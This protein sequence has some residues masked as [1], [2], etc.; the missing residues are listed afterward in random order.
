MDKSC[1][2]VCTKNGQV[3][4]VGEHSMLD[5]SP[6]IPLIRRIVRT[7]YKKLAARYC[8]DD[9]VTSAASDFGDDND[10]DDDDDDD[11]SAVS[12]IFANVWT[13][14]IKTLETAVQLSKMAQEQYTH[15]TNQYE[16]QVLVFDG[17]GKKFLKT[18]GM[19]SSADAV[20]QMAMQLASYR[21]FHGKQVATY[22]AALAR[23]F[24]HGRTATARPVSPQSRA[25]LQAMGCNDS[26]E[27]SSLSSSC[28]TADK[29]QVL[30]Q[31][32]QTLQEYQE[33]ASNG[34]CV[35]RHLFGLSM[36]INENDNDKVAPPKMFNDALY[37]RSK[38]W[39]LST[40]AFI[41][42]PGFGPVTDDGLGIGYCVAGDS[43]T[44]TVSSRKENN[45]VAPFCK[46][47]HEALTEI[48]QLLVENADATST[49]ATTTTTSTAVS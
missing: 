26:D 30:R 2:L 33:K 8:K 13:S 42:C 3:A 16:H 24:L 34:M 47:L 20:I 40:S 37:Q 7:S 39:R 35:D 18:T 4:Y 22:E 25:F 11:A 44:F 9:A 10:D 1:Q 45:L 49:A 6:T 48:G 28:T 27:S 19:S 15:L 46:L 36:M 29:M 12:N 31:A 23:Y 41:F 32:T 21:L 17:Y 43:C 5:A 38:H 14:S